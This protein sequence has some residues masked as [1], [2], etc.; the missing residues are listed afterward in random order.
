MAWDDPSINGLFWM[1]TSMDGGQTWSAPANT[2]D[3]ATGIGGVPVVQ[4][5]GTVVVPTS[6]DAGA[7]M[8]AFLLH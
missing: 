2:G 4:P 5:N 3:V 7:D 8:L 6:D 1:S